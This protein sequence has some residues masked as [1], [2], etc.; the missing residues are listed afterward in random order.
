ML[1]EKN[2]LTPK[3]QVIIISK[4][5]SFQDSQFI[6]IRFYNESSITSSINNSLNN[7][8]VLKHIKKTYVNFWKQIYIKCTLNTYILS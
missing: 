6:K 8:K 4:M 5:T 2:V 7:R 3:H 1:Y